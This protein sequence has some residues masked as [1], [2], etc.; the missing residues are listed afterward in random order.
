MRV[1]T[2]EYNLVWQLSD[3]DNYQFDKL[4]N[5]INI[6]TNRKLKMTVVGYTTGYCIKGKFRSLKQIK[7]KLVKIK[8][9][10]CP[11]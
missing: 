4:G 2:G 9:D 1:I 6:K 7:S 8:K 5:C 10:E 3:A 11:F